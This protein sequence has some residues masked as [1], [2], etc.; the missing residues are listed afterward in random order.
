MVERWEG[1]ALSLVLNTDAMDFIDVQWQECP[2]EESYMIGRERWPASLSRLLIF[3]LSS[4]LQPIVSLVESPTV[5][6]PVHN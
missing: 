4:A 5:R 3:S 1:E 2:S 6:R